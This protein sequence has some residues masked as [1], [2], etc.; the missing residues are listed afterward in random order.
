MRSPN[1]SVRSPLTRDLACPNS[2]PA[3]SST[4]NDLFMLLTCPL[5][6]SHG[7]SIELSGVQNNSTNTVLTVSK[8]LVSLSLGVTQIT[9]NNEHQCCPII[10]EWKELFMVAHLCGVPLA[11]GLWCV[12]FQNFSTS[13]LSFNILLSHLGKIVVLS[14]LFAYGEQR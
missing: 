3:C 9:D 7:C 6:Q 5:T 12:W 14:S 1:S 10:T 2:S 11:P 8:V 13:S 4:I